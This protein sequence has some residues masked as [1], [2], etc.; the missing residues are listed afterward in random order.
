MS[1]DY[2]NEYH[3]EYDDED[4]NL[5]YRLI[6][7]F[8]EDNDNNEDTEKAFITSCFKITTMNDI[9]DMLRHFYMYDSEAV[10][11]ITG[12]Y[13]LNLCITNFR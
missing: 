4:I 6:I 13:L 8:N 2:K 5:L 3:Y 12:E 9:M 11:E 7:F 10:Y 1:R